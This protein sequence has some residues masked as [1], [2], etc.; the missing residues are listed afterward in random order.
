MPFLH[1]T[2]SFSVYE[3]AG[4]PQ[5]LATRIKDR[6]T[7]MR[8][9][10]N[11]LR[12]ILLAVHRMKGE[13]ENI[14]SA[15]AEQFSYIVVD[16]NIFEPQ[17]GISLE[18]LYITVTTVAIILAITAALVIIKKTSRKSKLNN[19]KRRFAKQNSASKSLFLD[20]SM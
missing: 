2:E 1:V 5:I 19:L 17:S 3:E 6:Y 4:A 13:I 14:Q 18:T 8:V 15:Y 7:E 20:K 10:Q 9:Y 12:L 11:L 16:T